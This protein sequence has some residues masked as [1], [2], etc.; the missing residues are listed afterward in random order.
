MLLYTLFLI[1]TI[2]LRSSDDHVFYER[3]DPHDNELLFRRSM[4]EHTTGIE[5]EKWEA[6]VKEELFNREQIDRY[7]T[8]ITKESRH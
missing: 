8:S 6:A 3:D 7:F 4:A 5:K 2:I 1:F